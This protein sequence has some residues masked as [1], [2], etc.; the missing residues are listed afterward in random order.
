VL[1]IAKIAISLGLS[2]GGMATGLRS[3]KKS[4][5]SLEGMTKDASFNIASSLAKITIL[6]L[7]L[8]RALSAVTEPYNEIDKLSKLA[9]TLG[10][11]SDTA[12]H[13]LFALQFAMERSG[14]NAQNMTVG[15]R[16]LAKA[17][18]EAQMGMGEGKLAMQALGVTSEEVNRLSLMPLTEQFRY[19]MG[20]LQA[21]PNAAQRAAAAQRLFGEA[22]AALAGVRGHVAGLADEYTRL[23]GVLTG[24]QE[25]TVVFAV[26]RLTDLRT[27]ARGFFRQLAAETAPLVAIMSKIAAELAI[28]LREKLAGMGQWLMEG[29]TGEGLADTVA[30]LKEGLLGAVEALRGVFTTFIEGASLLADSLMSFGDGSR[31]FGT[32]LMKVTALL[33]ALADMF[34]WE[35]ERTQSWAET[36]A[37][38]VIKETQGGAHLSE[39]EKASLLGEM[40][41]DFPLPEGTRFTALIDGWDKSVRRQMEAADKSRQVWEEL[42]NRL[43][44][45]TPIAREG[46]G[47]PDAKARIA[48]GLAP[49]KPASTLQREGGLSGPPSLGKTG[50]GAAV[51]GTMEWFNALSSATEPQSAAEKTAEN[52][53][54]M[55]STLTNIFATV[56]AALTIAGIGLPPMTSPYQSEPAMAE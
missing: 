52:T 40:G 19:L 56:Q 24:A 50:F 7:A 16:K 45:P 54:A 55:S 29:M 12:A 26:D 36:A 13:N 2:T 47:L 34:K 51:M 49:A 35:K 38:W 53:A 43:R 11:N 6:Y 15:L 18:G 32:M 23:A 39:A 17:I 10:E 5:G 48:L 27:A 20:R 1:N 46:A 14:V 9:T 33:P 31:E 25:A 41:K 30:A 37:E 3:A 42:L 22:G 4:L 28:A 21:L 8:R 44:N